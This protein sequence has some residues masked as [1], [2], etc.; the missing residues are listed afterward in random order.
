MSLATALMSNSGLLWQCMIPGQKVNSRAKQRSVCFLIGPA[1]FA[2][3]SLAASC[4]LAAEP[5]LWP[6]GSFRAYAYQERGLVR[7][8]E[9]GVLKLKFLQPIV[10]PY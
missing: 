2:T 8:N 10:F 9:W 5:E 3:R 1:I 4:G 7:V 6:W